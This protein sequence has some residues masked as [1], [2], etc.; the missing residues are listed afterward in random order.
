MIKFSDLYFRAALALSNTQDSPQVEVLPQEPGWQRFFGTGLTVHNESAGNCQMFL[1][2][3]FVEELTH[4]KRPWY[5]ER[6]RAGEGGGR[7]WDGW[8]APPSQWTQVWANSGRWWRTGKLGV[9]PSTGSQRVRHDLATE[10]QQQ[11]LANMKHPF[12][13]AP[14]LWT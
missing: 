7:G 1:P 3:N 12:S 9:L 10:Q 6:L 8:I 2:L 11:Q 13:L 4:W 5:W 14:W